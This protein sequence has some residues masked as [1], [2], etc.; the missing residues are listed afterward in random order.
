MVKGFWAVDDKARTISLW[1]K[2]SDLSGTITSWGQM[3]MVNFGK[4]GL[5][6]ANWV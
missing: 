4:L 1:I 3:E 6:T 5:L 2:S